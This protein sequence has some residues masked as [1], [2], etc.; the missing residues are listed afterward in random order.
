ARDV[1][2]ILRH[3]PTAVEGIDAVI[4]SSMRSRRGDDAVAD[5]PAARAW[6]F[7]ELDD[8]RGVGPD[9][10][11]A[12]RPGM[13]VGELTSGA[14]AAEAMAVSGPGARADLWRVRE[15]GA[16]LSSRITDPDTG[17]TTESWPGWEDS[18]VP[19]ERL[20]DY[21]AEFR[22]LLTEHGLT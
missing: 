3:R 22:D 7:I 19:P 18:A 13:L 2:A 17:V 14:H 4:A 1:P 9:A 10:T 11:P 6:L 20:A 5:L 15:D 21:L 12:A 8:E 16:G